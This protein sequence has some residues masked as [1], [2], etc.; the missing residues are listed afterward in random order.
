MSVVNTELRRRVI[1][2]YK[3]KLRVFS[4][5]LQNLR[6]SNVCRW[7]ILTLRQILVVLRLM[8]RLNFVKSTDHSTTKPRAL[9]FPTHLFAP[10][11]LSILFTASLY[12]IRSPSIQLLYLGREYPLGYDY[13]RP[14]LHKAFSA[15]AALRDEEAIRR[16][17]ERAE[18]VKKGTL[19]SCL[20]FF[21]SF[22]GFGGWRVLRPWTGQVGVGF[23]CLHVGGECVSWCTS[24][25]L[26]ILYAPQSPQSQPSKPDAAL[27]RAWEV[28]SMKYLP[29]SA[30]AS[31]SGQLSSFAQLRL[32]HARLPKWTTSLY[33][34]NSIRVMTFHHSRHGLTL[35]ISSLFPPHSKSK[36]CKSAQ[37]LSPALSK[38]G[39]RLRPRP[40]N[41]ATSSPQ[42]HIITSMTI[43]E[44]SILFNG[45]YAVQRVPLSSHPA[46]PPPPPS[47]TQTE[48][49]LRRVS[50][51]SKCVLLGAIRTVKV[52]LPYILYPPSSPPLPENQ[53]KKTEG[54][55]R[56][57]SIQRVTTPQ[58]ATPDRP[59][60]RR[61]NLP[62][63]FTSSTLLETL[64]KPLIRSHSTM[65]YHPNNSYQVGPCPPSVLTS[66]SSN[67]S[68][69]SLTNGRTSQFEMLIDW[70]FPFTARQVAS[71]E[72]PHGFHGKP[73][74]LFRMPSHS[75]HSRL[76]HMLLQGAIIPLITLLSQH[77]VYVDDV[78]VDD[79]DDD[80]D[81]GVSR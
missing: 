20:S 6:N 50:L 60:R 65:I 58:L 38:K 24:M 53:S 77:R 3:G 9:S 34:P 25:S 42:V 26:D 71:V 64:S 69:A 29:S 18:F 7:R 67:S 36:H 33:S 41:F 10:R 27:F 35:C 48:S 12:N 80:V 19:S 32:F 39:P 62:C 68:P 66:N 52:S 44:S 40:S 75:M 74:T 11:P 81:D 79:D 14:R 8:M 57:R 70:R 45:T 46:V 4:V 55:I 54:M 63:L 61:E 22:S 17:I 73:I 13:F 49:F 72:C 78:V 76:Q 59:K 21:M 2:I 43:L 23:F 47:N 16:G 15:N 31:S 1:A 30:T 37:C 5:L 56:Y 51:Q 28:L